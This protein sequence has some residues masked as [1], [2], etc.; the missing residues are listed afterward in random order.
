MSMTYGH[1][2][3]EAVVAALQGQDRDTGLNLSC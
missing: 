1:S 2:A 3:T